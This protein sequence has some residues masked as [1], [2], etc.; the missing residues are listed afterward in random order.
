MSDKLPAGWATVNFNEIIQ[1]ALG[2]DWG[3]DS[4]E[5]GDGL[6]RVRVLR[7]T[8]FKT[9]RHNKGVGAAERRI[10]VS[11]LDRRRLQKGDIVLEVSGGGPDQPVA[12]TILIDDEALK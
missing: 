8:E 3:K 10:K 5:P 6:E 2:G 7:G 9:W 11:S 4:G 12:R 1:L